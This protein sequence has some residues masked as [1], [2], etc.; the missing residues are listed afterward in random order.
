MEFKETKIEIART[1]LIGNMWRATRCYFNNLR[2][3]LTDVR[4]GQSLRDAHSI[5]HAGK[6]Q[7]GE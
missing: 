1:T 6:L 5:A 7:S 4:G 3:W 2:Q